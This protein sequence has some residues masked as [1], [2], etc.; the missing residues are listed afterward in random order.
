MMKLIY[1]ALPILLFSSCTK[2][3]P[4]EVKVENNPNIHYLEWHK[5]GQQTKHDLNGDGVFDSKTQLY[6][7]SIPED[8]AGIT[9]YRQI[10][11]SE[12]KL[13]T[14]KSTFKFEM[15]ADQTNQLLFKEGDLIDNQSLIKKHFVNLY[16]NET[17]KH[18]DATYLTKYEY[19]FEATNGFGY[20]AVAYTVD[21]DIYYGWIKIKAAY[22]SLIMWESGFQKMPNTPIRIGEK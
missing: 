10:V 15:Y 16:I 7:G 18:P 22:K 3:T 8:S 19:P 9:I 13:D 1:I 21:E 5:S 11:A 17:T 4:V 6:I 20:I 2:E 12:L 14:W